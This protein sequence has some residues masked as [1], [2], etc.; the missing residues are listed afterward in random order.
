MYRKIYCFFV[1]LLLVSSVYS[2]GFGNPEILKK[3]GLSEDVIEQIAAIHMKYQQEIQEAEI[4]LKVYRAQLEKLLFKRDVDLIKVEKL[5]KESMEW[6]L[7]VEMA[8]IKQRTEVRLLM[9]EET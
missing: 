2:Q 1:L 7:K 9:D 3:F 8:R 5:L 4:E 6:K